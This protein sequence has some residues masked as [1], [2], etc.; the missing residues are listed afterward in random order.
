M[1]IKNANLPACPITDDRG[2][3][4]MYGDIQNIEPLCFGL[5]KLED[6]TKAALQGIMTNTNS[7]PTEQYHFDN[8][9]ED[10]VRAAKTTLK[11]LEKHL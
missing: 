8:I 5:T 9:A 10:A 4:R 6:F 1:T 3:P 2:F 7:C 11:E